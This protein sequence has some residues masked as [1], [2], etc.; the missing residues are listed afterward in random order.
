ML[1]KSNANVEGMDDFERKLQELFVEVKTLLAMGNK[2]DAM[3][4]LEANYVMVKE[5]VNCG[6][7]GIEQ[8]ALLDILALGYVGAGEV[9]LLEHVLDMV[10]TKRFIPNYT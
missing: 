2:D 1:D 9:P 3:V 8:A 7:K 5:Q 6:S 4:L 10:S